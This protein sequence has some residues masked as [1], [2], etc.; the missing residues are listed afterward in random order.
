M[1]ILLNLTKFVELVVE[2]AIV[3]LGSFECLPLYS[4]P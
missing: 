1:E 3:E 2:L 4:L